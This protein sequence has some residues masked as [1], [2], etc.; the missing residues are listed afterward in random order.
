LK[1]QMCQKSF[2][3]FKMLLMNRTFKELVELLGSLSE[4]EADTN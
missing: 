2:V 1:V 4:K 3:K